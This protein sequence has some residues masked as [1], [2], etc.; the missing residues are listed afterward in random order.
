MHVRVCVYE[1]FP[2]A[3]MTKFL[4]RVLELPV[5]G[6]TEV[7]VA[8]P[9]LTLGDPVDYTVHGVLQ[10]RTLEWAAVPFS[11]GSS[12]PGIKPRSP[13]LQADAS[14]SATREAWKHWSG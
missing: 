9:C 8:Q 10:A 7:K 12:H 2:E 6:H 5:P 4:S 13:T 14:L 11:R 1:V 3:V